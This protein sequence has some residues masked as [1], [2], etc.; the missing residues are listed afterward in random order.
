VLVVLAAQAAWGHDLWI[1]RESHPLLRAR[2]VGARGP[3]LHRIRSGRGAA[4]GVLRRER[5]AVWGR[6]VW[7]IPGAHRRWVRRSLLPC[8]VLSVPS[9]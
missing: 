7:G 1:E 3:G 9:L 6:A 4:G 2:A 8:L 5:S